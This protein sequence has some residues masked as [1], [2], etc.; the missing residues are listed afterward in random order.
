MNY[1]IS[2]KRKQTTLKYGFKCGLKVVI[3][4]N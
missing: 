2:K 1:F 4:I 3:Y